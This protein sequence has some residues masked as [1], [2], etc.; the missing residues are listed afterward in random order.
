MDMTWIM[1]SQEFIA[2][3]ARNKTGK[4]KGKRSIWFNGT[5]TDKA[6]GRKVEYCKK[7]FEKYAAKDFSRLTK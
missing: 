4:N 6:T 3:A 5:K 2:E 7:Q 1:T